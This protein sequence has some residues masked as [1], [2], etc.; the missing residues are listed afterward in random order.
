M[1]RNCRIF[2]TGSGGNGLS[3]FVG[4]KFVQEV[5]AVSLAV[6]Q[7]YPECGSVIEL[8]GQD[9]KIIIFKKDPETGRKKKIPSMNDKCAGGTGAVIDKINAKLR[10]PA[11]QLCEMG[12]NGIKLHPVAGKCGVFAETD[13]N[14]LQKMGVPPD[15]LMASLFE[16]IVMQNLSVLTRGNTLQPVVLLL[17]GPNC[18]IKGMRDCWKSNIPKI[19]EERN[20]PLPEGVPPEDLIKTP[21]NAQYFAATRLG[22]I[23]Q[24]R[25]RR[26]S[27]VS[28]DW[29]KLEWYVHIG[30]EEEKVE[31]GRHRRPGEGR[32]TNW[33]RSRRNTAT[34]S[35]SRPRSSRARWWK[36]S[37]A[38]TAAPPPPRPCCFRKTTSAGFWPRRTSFPRATPSRTRWTCSRSWTGRF[39]DQGAELK[40]LGVGTTGYAKDIL[41][42]VIGADAALVETVAHTEAGLHFYD[43]VDVICDVGG[44]DIKII[45]LKNGRVKDFKLNTQ[46]S[47]GNG[48]FL[49]ST[50]QGFN[51]PVEEYADTAFGAKGFP[52]FGYGCAVFMQ[53]DIVDFQRQGWKPEEIMAGLCNVLPKNI[54]LYVS[55]IPNLSAIG[56]RFLLQGGTQY[57]LAAVKAQVDF[58][59]SRFKG[60]ERPGGRDRARALRRSRAR[61]ARRSKRGAC[62]TTAAAARSSAWTP[63]GPSSTRRRATKRRAATSARTSACARSS[64]SRRRSAIPTT[65]RR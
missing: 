40:I 26:T 47:A 11:E 8:G 7:L 48:Y 14:G 43:D 21:D 52:S 19:W 38:S 37:S 58:I 44:Q 63:A 34:R 24:E 3:K 61:S 35:S 20:T 32:R 12:Y 42:D 6:E 9:A 16:A 53:S 29:E 54:W 17:G 51:V 31:A 50:A 49:Q 10:I 60:K 62:G 2:I 1:P 15:E 56:R 55:Q 59:E 25:R 18:Y 27:A 45:I 4:A 33:R 39:C 46:C 64:T 36:A 5:N 23:R 30:R 28:S 65:S 57:N 41:K 13:I 22:R